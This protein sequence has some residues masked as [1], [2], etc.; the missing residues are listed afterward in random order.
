MNSYPIIVHN[1]EVR[2][3]N[4]EKSI[5]TL[6]ITQIGICLQSSNLSLDG[7]LKYVLY[8]LKQFF[9]EY[10]SFMKLFMGVIQFCLPLN[11]V[12]NTFS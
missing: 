10:P 3:V 11:S 4:K 5:R 7:F 12:P 2:R 1:I 8:I 6:Q 9:K